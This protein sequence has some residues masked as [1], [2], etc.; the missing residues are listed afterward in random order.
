M[1]LDRPQQGTT[2]ST[3]V[4]IALARAHCDLAAQALESQ[5]IADGFDHLQEA[6][7]TLIK[8]SPNHELLGT[9]APVV[10]QIHI[11]DATPDTTS[12]VTHPTWPSC[13]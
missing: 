9:H 1:W 2:S 6:R 3:D 12:F 11:F 7:S 5:K 8:Y 10:R 4:A 13:L